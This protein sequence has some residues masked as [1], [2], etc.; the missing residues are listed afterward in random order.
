MKLIGYHGTDAKN[1]DSIRQNSYEPSDEK[2]WFGSGIYFFETFAPLT[3][4]FEEAKA[5]AINVMKVEQWAV[6]KAQIES[7]HFLDLFNNMTHREMYNRIRAQLLMKHRQSRKDIAT[8][9]ENVVFKELRKDDHFD[10]IR[11]PVDAARNEPYSYV[12]GRFQ[13]QICVTRKSCIKS[14]TLLKIGEQR[15]KIWTTEFEF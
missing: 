13:I 6:F 3:D 15:K 7:D 1:V 11:V 8:F 10:V 5:W 4:G 12:I 2:A 14:N 9:R